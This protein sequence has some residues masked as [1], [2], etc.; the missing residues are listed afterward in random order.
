MSENKTL[1]YYNKNA[2]G[3]AE[4]TIDVDF[5]DTQKHF[6]NLLPEQ[7]C[8]LDFGCGSGRDTKYFLS[9]N[10]QVDAIDGSEELCRIAS[11]YVGIKVKKMLFKE[12]EEIEKYDGIWACAS[13]LHIPQKELS[14]VFGKMVKAL[15]SEGIIYA[16]FKYGNF[17]GER[18]GRYFTDFTEEKFNK[19]VQNIENV[20]LKEEWITCDVRPDRGE[21]QWL[22]LILQKN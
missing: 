13:I 22:N 1:D 21:E 9:Q 10:F 8:I 2:S 14:M 11:G 12:L 4:T 19:F 3:F 6:Q 7:G 5:Y 16:S 18:N 17:E 15:K 20:K